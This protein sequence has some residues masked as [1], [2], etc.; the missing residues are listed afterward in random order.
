MTR[1]LPY[2]SSTCHG[3]PAKP[4]RSGTRAG[5]PAR[6]RNSAATRSWRCSGPMA[7]GG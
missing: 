2:P 1:S 6:M 4:G 3:L 5:S 7:A